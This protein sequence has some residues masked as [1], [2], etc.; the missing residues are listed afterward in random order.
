MSPSDKVRCITVR[1][2]Q[3]IKTELERLLPWNYS[4][5]A[6]VPLI[7]AFIKFL[8]KERAR[9]LLHLADEQDPELEIISKSIRYATA[10]PKATNTNDSTEKSETGAQ[11]P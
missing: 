9:Y 11:Q 2:E 8:G 10:L 4:S 3:S 5:K 7:E 1:V 6:F